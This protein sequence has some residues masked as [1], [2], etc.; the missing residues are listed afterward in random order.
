MNIIIKVRDIIDKIVLGM[1]VL[2]LAG[3]AIFIGLQ[4]FFRTIGIGIDWTEEFARFSFIGVTFLGSAVAI[5]R[6]RHIVIDF[7]VVRLPDIIRRFLLVAIHLAISAFM[8]V[9]MYG[10]TIIMRAAQGVS[11]NSVMWFQLNYMHGVVFAG[12]V[13][14]CISAFIRALEYALF[15]K[16]LPAAQGG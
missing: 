13:L 9:C 2:L 6:N 8:I 11:S 3:I 15:K 4:I 1:A 5:T 16:E 7:L 14:M 10:L 12:C